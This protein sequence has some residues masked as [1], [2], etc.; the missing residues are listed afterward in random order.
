MQNA[1]SRVVK[2]AFGREPESI[3]NS[4][5]ARFRRAFLAEIKEL[6]ESTKRYSDGSGSYI[7]G[8]TR[9]RVR[10]LARAKARHAVSM[11]GGRA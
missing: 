7:G 9:R 11:D 5:P 3:S 6:K 10:D 8:A 1:I 4:R 2:R